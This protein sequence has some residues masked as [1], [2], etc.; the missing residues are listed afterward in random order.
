MFLFRLSTFLLGDATG[1]VQESDELE[2]NTSLSSRGP[3]FREVQGLDIKVCEDEFLYQIVHS[4][5]NNPLTLR[6][7]AE[8]EYLENFIRLLQVLDMITSPLFVSGVVAGKHLKHAGQSVCRTRIR[9]PC[10]NPYIQFHLTVVLLCLCVSG[11]A[12]TL[13]TGLEQ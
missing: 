4:Q 9:K 3:N 8:L 6:K 11:I 7:C 1:D 5:F 13:R 10:N 12:L 2:G